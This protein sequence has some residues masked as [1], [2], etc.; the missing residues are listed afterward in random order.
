VLK[1]KAKRLA[2]AAPSGLVRATVVIGASAA[3]ASAGGCGV[4][5][6]PSG[7]TVRG[8]TFSCR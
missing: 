7:C 4:L 5:F 6:A 2:V 1:L 3:D 8:S